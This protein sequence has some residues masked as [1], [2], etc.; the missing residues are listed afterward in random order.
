MSAAPPEV[1]Q[2]HAPT[3]SAMESVKVSRK[4]VPPTSSSHGGNP[5]CY[6]QICFNM[7]IRPSTLGGTQARSLPP[8]PGYNRSI[9]PALPAP[10]LSLSLSLCACV[11]PSF[12]GLDSTLV[13]WVPPEPRRCLVSM[14]VS[15]SSGVLL[16]APPNILRRG[17]GDQD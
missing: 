15:F 13:E 14:L 6:V 3:V 4:I 2:D 17:K 7:C 16:R 1:A 8:L 9:G 10:S 5:R 11:L 12:G